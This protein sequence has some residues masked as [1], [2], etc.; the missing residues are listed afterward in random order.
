LN[1]SISGSESDSES[2][3]DDDAYRLSTLV[4][5]KAAISSSNLN[6]TPTSL[7]KQGAGKAPLIWFTSPQL[8][9]EVSLGVYRALFSNTEQAEGNYLKYIRNK[10]LTA[11]PKDPHIFLCMIGGGHF[12]AMIIS[13]APKAGKQQGAGDRQ[14]VILEH[15]TFHR[16][17]TRRKQGGS[18]SANDNSKGNAHSAGA[19]IRRHNEA[20]LINEVRELL[21]SWKGLLDTA[22]LLFIR[23]S[24]TANR[25]TLFSY[26]DAILKANDPRIR[27]FPFSTRRATQSELMRSFVELTRI[28][29]SR[30]D[31]TALAALAADTHKAPTPVK[32]KEPSP[33]PPKLSK[34]EEEALLHTSQLNALI[35]RSKAPAVLSYLT[36]NKLPANYCFH[37]PSQYHHSPTPLHLAASLNSP[38]VVFALLV[39]AFADPTQLNEDSKTP[40]ELAGDRAT[41]DAFR[42]ARSELGEKKWD[43][44]AARVPP[45]LKK[46]QA[47][48]RER[49]ERE[50][51]EKGEKE[52]REKEMARLKEAE[53][54][55]KQ[56]KA[57]PGVSLG[58]GGVQ[59]GLSRIEEET[60]GLSA[61]AKM[62]LER[63]R[64]ARAAEERIKK[65]Q[66]R[67]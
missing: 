49:R 11:Q 14:A 38:A 35:R 16:Y 17:T 6:D 19:S 29:V 15:K 46:N 54:E 48:A 41:R 12:A 44:E 18:Q 51:A 26:E 22:K 66:N 59:T 47:E 58:S 31:E 10:Q 7:R 21:A 20:M 40:F 63:E 4:R 57:K 61:E 28:K 5:R 64:R 36:S 1:E 62:R 67:S 32:P 56:G 23:A 37:P 3:S 25:R 2:G 60:R 45:A 13:L 55:R 30:V 39:K 43:W 53:K 8:P 52:R 24:G 27:G 65:M 42:V 33:A 34:E 50:E 9:K